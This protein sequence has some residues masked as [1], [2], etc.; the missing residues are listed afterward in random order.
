MLQFKSL[1]EK[2][3]M[4]LANTLP[5]TLFNLPNSQVI[6]SYFQQNDELVKTTDFS[7]QGFVFAPFN[8]NE[9][10]ILFKTEVCEVSET[11]FS[12]PTSPKMKPTNASE[13]DTK[14]KDSHIQ[15]VNQAVKAINTTA[16]NKVVLSRP[17]TQETTKSALVLF[18]ELLQLYPS[19]FTYIWYHPKVGLWLG[20]TPETL[21]QLNGLHFKTVA[22]AGTKTEDKLLEDWGFK[23]L[24]EQAIVTT[25]IKDALSPFTRSINESD[26]ETVK[27]GHI[28]HLKTNLEGFLKPNTKLSNVLSSL[29]PTPAVS[30]F[31]KELAYSYITQN[32]TYDR[33]F[34]T[35]FLGEL[36]VS[37]INKNNTEN[38]AYR[39]QRLTT[40]LFVNLR[41]LS[42]QNNTATIYVGSGITKDSDPELEYIETVRK[43]E[44][45]LKAL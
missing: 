36:N 29:H 7:E 5:F 4:Q 3:T 44:T 1:I 18:E 43:S 28:L 13:E 40:K 20:A 30:G 26:V 38:L 8:L 45:M 31:P 34:Y 32:E 22:L 11:Q 23:E 42:L 41:C 24:E 9:G 16:L 37:E 27:A 33:S 19:A 14:A 21:F 12:L 25:T 6:K 35:G 10:S 15:L 39:K 17:L 2:A